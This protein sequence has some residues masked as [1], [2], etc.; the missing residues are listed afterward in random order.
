MSVSAISQRTST[1]SSSD[2]SNSPVTRTSKLPQLK[3]KEKHRL[4]QLRLGPLRQVQTDLEQRLGSAA[5]EP[6]F[7]NVTQAAPFDSGRR[8]LKEF[9]INSTN[10]WKSA[11]DKF[12]AARAVR[13]DTGPGSLRKLK[14]K[15]D[16]TSEVIAGCRDDMKALWEDLVIRE[17]LS[18]R[19]TRIE[20]SAGLCVLISFLHEY[21][22]YIPHH[23]FL[24]D[25]ERIAVRNYQPT[26]DDVIRARLRTLGVQEYK[27]LFEHGKLGHALGYRHLKK[28]HISIRSFCWSGV[29][30]V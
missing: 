8:A 9:S 18:R 24:N 23:S 10:G 30:T 5:T 11:L 2:D 21:A 7:T 28:V 13:P 19:K 17:M 27:F 14:S 29:E 20:D 1:D 3:F 6:N 12:R 25:A 22:S 26:D 15:E 4:L 16:E